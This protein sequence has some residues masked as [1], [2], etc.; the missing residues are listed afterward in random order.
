MERGKDS[1]KDRETTPVTDGNAG[2]GTHHLAP[3]TEP[4]AH[5]LKENKDFDPGKSELFCLKLTKLYRSNVLP[6]TTLPGFGASAFSHLPYSDFVVKSTNEGRSTLVKVRTSPDGFSRIGAFGYARGYNV[7]GMKAWQDVS[8]AI[9]DDGLKEAFTIESFTSKFSSLPA[10]MTPLFGYLNAQRFS[11]AQFFSAFAPP[12]SAGASELVKRSTNSAF[13]KKDEAREALG[14]AQAY[15]SGKDFWQDGKGKTEHGGNSM[16]FHQYTASFRPFYS[17]KSRNDKT[18]M[19]YRDIMDAMRACVGTSRFTSVLPVVEEVVK[20]LSNQNHKGNSLVQQHG[21][22]IIFPIFLS[23]NEF[24]EYG[25]DEE[26][27]A[28]FLKREVEENLRE[29]ESTDH[30]GVPQASWRQQGFNDRGINDEISHDELSGIVSHLV[31]VDRTSEDVDKII[32]LIQQSCE[33]VAGLKVVTFGDRIARQ[34]HLFSIPRYA[35]TGDIMRALTTPGSI[36]NSQILPLR[37]LPKILVES[38][39]RVVSEAVKL[40]LPVIPSDYHRGENENTI[41]RAVTVTLDAIDGALGYKREIYGDL[42]RAIADESTR[43]DSRHEHN[44]VLEQ[45]IKTYVSDSDNAQI[46]CDFRKELKV[47]APYDQLYKYINSTIQSGMSHHLWSFISRWVDGGESSLSV[48]PEALG[49]FVYAISHPSS[50]G[51]VSKVEVASMIDYALRDGKLPDFFLAE[52]I[53]YI[54]A[55]VENYRF[56]AKFW[57][58]LCEISPDDVRAEHAVNILIGMA[59]E[60][61]LRNKKHSNERAAALRSFFV[62]WLPYAKLKREQFVQER[63][64]EE[65]RQGFSLEGIEVNSTLENPRKKGGERAQTRAAQD[66][67]TSM[68]PE[69]RVKEILREVEENGTPVDS[70]LEEM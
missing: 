62:V 57:K 44:D 50:I 65:E 48:S 6:R 47:T 68:P 37:P 59:N 35:H 26:T 43:S 53:D 28:E 27:L 14:W 34:Y 16:F 52:A 60:D 13:G 25:R 38:S 58:A 17:D 42:A 7:T 22:E 61:M 11:S 31:H 33:E 45:F 15:N 54:I 23:L 9:P 8:P 2:K 36:F 19:S 40:N 32:A 3:D 69:E 1:G 20:G 55:N 66:L 4:G 24:L 64:R 67:K 30:E 49:I 10:C 18:D 51:A 41:G 21:Y 29:E 70:L 5:A 39:K 12:H 63:K 56:P 46:I